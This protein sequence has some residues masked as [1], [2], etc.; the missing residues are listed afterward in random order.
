MA[1]NF[2][3]SALK[4]TTLSDLM[5]GRTKV[6]TD[7]M[8]K[9]FPN[10]FTIEDFDIVDDKKSQYPVFTVK[11][12]KGICFFGGTILMNMVDGWLEGFDSI[13]ACRAEF[14]EGGGLPVKLSTGKTKNGNNITKVEII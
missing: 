4:S 11:E 8:I 12:D 1:F 13:D 9:N 2:R 6:S 7:D 5:N 10:G 14:V 3:E